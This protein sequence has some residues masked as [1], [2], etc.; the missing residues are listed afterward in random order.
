MG[1]RNRRRGLSDRDR[2]TVTPSRT[3]RH[4]HES[5]AES[6]S[7]SESVRQ[8]PT[9]AVHTTDTGSWPV[10]S[11]AECHCQ[12]RTLR[13]SAIGPHSEGSSVGAVHS[14]AR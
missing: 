9:Q 12:C 6:E 1:C 14:E 8:T 5:R 2:L 4:W 11:S 13:L 3:S 10:R 7:E